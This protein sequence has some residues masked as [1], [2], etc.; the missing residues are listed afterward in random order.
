MSVGLGGRSLFCDGPAIYLEI[1]CIDSFLFRICDCCSRFVILCFV[2]I[3]LLR[4]F[5]VFG[6]S[7]AD[8]ERPTDCVRLT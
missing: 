8:N 4:L 6:D 1:I 7:L 3:P 5:C 2:C